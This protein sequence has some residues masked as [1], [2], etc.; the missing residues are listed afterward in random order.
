MADDGGFC[1]F[2]LSPVVYV[3]VRL[4]DGA[5]SVTSFLQMDLSVVEPGE[6]EVAGLAGVGS[7]A[8]VNITMD[9]P[10]DTC[11]ETF[12]TNITEKSLLF[13]GSHDVIV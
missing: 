12:G 4:E 7:E 9:P 5:G 3:I 6:G 13:V 8:S 1:L 2:P 10:L 11:L